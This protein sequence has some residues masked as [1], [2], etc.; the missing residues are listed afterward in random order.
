MPGFSKKEQFQLSRLVLA[1]RGSLSKV[2]QHMSESETQMQV[3]ALR[4][5]VLFYRSRIDID[6]PEIRVEW[7]KTDIRILLSRDWLNL[8][9]LTETALEKEAKEWKNIGLKLAISDLPD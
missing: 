2:K 9:P 4:L 8:N 5:A 7:D 3:L 1:Q 6:L